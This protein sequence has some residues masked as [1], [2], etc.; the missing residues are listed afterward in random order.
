[1]FELYRKL[2]G[3]SVYSGTKSAGRA[4]ALRLHL[5]ANFNVPTTGAS[6][7][8]M[9]QQIEAA[10]SNLGGWRY[11]N[12]LHKK[13]VFDTFR[14]R[15]LAGYS[16]KAVDVYINDGRQG[17]YGS[18][19]GNDLFSERL[20]LDT[21]WETQDIWVKVTPY[22]D[23]ASQQAGDPGDHQ[24]P[25]VGSTAYLYVRVGNRGAEM[26]GS[27]SV[28]VK[29][30]HADPGIG[31]T[32]PEDWVPM[33]APTIT[34]TNIL[35]GVA[36]HVVVGPFPWIPTVVGHECVLAVVE[37]ANDH[38]VTQDLLASDHVA[39][40]DLVP[41]DNN[42]AQ[43]NLAPTPAKT[44]GK[45]RFVVRNPFTIAKV[46]DLHTYTTLPEGWQWRLAE[47]RIPLAAG[48]RRWV[49][50][51]ID[52]AAGPE[53]TRFDKPFQ[54][55]VT[56][57]IDDRAIGGMTFYLAPPSAFP[58]RRGDEDQH[59]AHALRD[60]LSLQI[61]WKDCTFEGELDLRLRFRKP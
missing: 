58:G 25:P 19:S 28:T 54:V 31:L 52:R 39:D 17:G 15:H 13:V 55:Q 44:G 38:A 46:L 27:G 32:W 9:G 36:N 37:C 21:W 5:Q 51:T 20:W 48:E 8:Q 14:R 40:G 41:F 34:V 30:F 49:E 6:A 47:E 4:L 56:G 61:P 33:T 50:L 16:D 60:L 57:V 3:D 42:I 26:G 29:A 45:Y 35:P 10:D 59:A 43:R 1:V 12:G 23:A 2:G 7:Q 53:V 11:A 22:P 24:E 18:L